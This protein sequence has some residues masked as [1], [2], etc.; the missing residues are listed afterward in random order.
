MIIL[1]VY[2]I[3]RPTA[4]KSNSKDSSKLGMSSG[5]AK[6]IRLRRASGFLSSVTRV[7]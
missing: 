1:E 2:E 5:S 3:K 4:L 6:K 7:A